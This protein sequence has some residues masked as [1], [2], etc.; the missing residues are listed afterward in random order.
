MDH[1]LEGQYR[2]MYMAEKRKQLEEE[3]VPISPLLSPHHP[4]LAAG[5]SYPRQCLEHLPLIVLDLSTPPHYRSYASHRSPSSST[6]YAPD[7]ERAV[8]SG[9]GA[10]A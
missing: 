9:A 3:Q 5:S 10:P 6:S 7:A 1:P 4:R 2:Q 8:Q